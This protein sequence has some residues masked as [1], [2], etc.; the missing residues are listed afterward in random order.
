MTGGTRAIE[1]FERQAGTL[2]ELREHPMSWRSV[3]DAVNRIVSG[4]GF[5]REEVWY[6]YLQAVQGDSAE[7]EESF[8]SPEQSSQPKQPPGSSNRIQHWVLIEA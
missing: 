3:I 4:V 5:T 1:Q 6:V 7:T 8:R 2:S